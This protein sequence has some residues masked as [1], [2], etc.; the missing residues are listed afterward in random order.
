METLIV[1]IVLAI[2]FTLAVIGKLTGKTKTTFEKAGY[3][4]AM[5]YATAA[6]EV[7]FTIGLFTKYEWFA[8]TGLLVIIAGGIV[9]L[10]RQKAKPVQ[11]TLPVVT[12]LLLL[13]LVFSM[14][15][16]PNKVCSFRTNTDNRTNKLYNFEVCQSRL[17]EQ[18]SIK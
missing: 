6:A 3:G 1:K 11:I 10:L 12:A 8:A 2:I 7:I 5:M 18:P 17:Q 15:Q 13:G 4:P 16:L 9:T 14:Q